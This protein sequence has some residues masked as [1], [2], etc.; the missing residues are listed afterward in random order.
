MRLVWY[1]R[2][3]GC[4]FLFFRAVS[5]TFLG[6]V[7]VQL[8]LSFPTF[9]LLLLLW[10]HTHRQTQSL[11][12]G[13]VSGLMIITGRRFGIKAH[14]PRALDKCEQC[15]RSQR[16]FFFLPLPDLQG[17]HHIVYLE[18]QSA[19]FASRTSVIRRSHFTCKK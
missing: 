1:Y 17:S 3:F 16:G 13:E 12:F 14:A 4:F 8:S 10:L 15:E 6:P 19:A 5:D 2:L 7:Q 18:F 9:A 11:V